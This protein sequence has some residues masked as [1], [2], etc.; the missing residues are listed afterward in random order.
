LFSECAALGGAHTT[1]SAIDAPERNLEEAFAFH[2]EGFREDP[3]PIAIPLVST[4]FEY[5]ESTS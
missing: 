5:R 3:P 2:L 4:R 1:G